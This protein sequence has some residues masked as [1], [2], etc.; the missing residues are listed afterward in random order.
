MALERLKDKGMDSDDA[1][2]ELAAMG[3]DMHKQRQ[4]QAT[5][6]SARS[7][8][9]V[10]VAAAVVQLLCVLTTRGV[11]V[12]RC[13]SQPMF[14]T[15]GV[16][17][18]AQAVEAKR[19]AARAVAELRSMDPGHLKMKT[20][21]FLRLESEARER[22]LLRTLDRARIEIPKEAEEGSAMCRNRKVFRTHYVADCG[23]GVVQAT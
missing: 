13:R 12:R 5:A 8:E 21:K 23:Q 7:Q 6:H 18:E 2:E 11:L 10:G 19:R 16:K 4:S 3:Y 20:D 9:Y 22:A 15:Q 17:G 1:A 14:I